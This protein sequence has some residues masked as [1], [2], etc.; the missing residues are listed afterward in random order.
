MQS[1]ALNGR[2]AAWTVTS[3]ALLALLSCGDVRD[4]TPSGRVLVIGI[5]G[6]SL[7][8]IQPLMQQGR[9]PHLESIA[10]KGVSGPLKSHHPL[11]SPRVWTSVATGKEPDKHGIKSWVKSTGPKTTRL[12]Y[13]SD[14]KGHALWNILSEA[15]Y[16]VGVV[17]WLMTYP[18]EVV[19]GVL[20][21]DH[22][23][24]YEVDGKKYLAR[25]FSGRSEPEPISVEEERNA[26]TFPPSWQARSLSEHHTRGELTNVPNPFDGNTDLPGQDFLEQY[27]LFYEQDERFASIALEIELEIQPSLL[28]VL[29]QGIDRTSHFL[30]AGFEPAEAYSEKRR[31]DRRQQAAA[32]AALETYYEFT[33]ALIGLFLER[34]DEHD[35]VLVVSDHGFEAAETGVA[36]T[37][38]HISAEA[39]DG[40]V[41]AR[42]PGIEKTSKPDMSVNDVTPLILAWLGEPLAQDMDGVVPGFF[43]GNLVEPIETYDTTE[44]MRLEGSGSGSEEVLMEQLRQLGY[45]D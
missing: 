15:G 31:I 8:V 38:G 39:E 24:S 40:I 12:L 22:T 33:D 37:G 45:V 5:D 28:M 29:L 16:T 34:Y 25:I 20:V 18:P 7:R 14:R 10:Q 11:L 2:R 6:A 13:S 9:L 41:F 30:W 19:H 4:E 17:N 44:I 23:T 1:T 42:G 36:H 27:S 35:L 3:A 26:V 21:S 43:K 32:R